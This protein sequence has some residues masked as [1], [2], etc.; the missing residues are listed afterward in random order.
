MLLG[1]FDCPGALMMEGC[2]PAG[3][4][5]EEGRLLKELKRKC[6]GGIVFC[7]LSITWKLDKNLNYIAPSQN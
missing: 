4:R 2:S 1:A 5:R 3:E 7:Q 6:V